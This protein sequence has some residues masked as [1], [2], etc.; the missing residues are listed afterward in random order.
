M[1]CKQIVGA[2]LLIVVTGM[3][4][5][6]TGTGGEGGTRTRPA[7]QL[8]P[9]PGDRTTN[10][11]PGLPASV[12][13]TEGVLQRV[14]LTSQDGK[15]VAGAFSPDRRS[16]RSTQPL[17]FGQTYTWSGTAAVGPDRRLLP[18]T[19]SFSTVAP[20]QE[21]EGT[22]NID[23]GAVVGVAAPIILQFDHEV[24]DK[25]AVERVLQ[26]QASVPT[27]GAWAWLPDNDDGSR[28]HYRPRNYWLP[29]TQVS[30][31]ARLYGLPYGEGSY[32]TQDLKAH[33]TVGR[34]QIVKADVESHRMIVV[35]DGREVMNFP[36]SYGLASDPVRNT[37]NGIHVVMSKAETVLM[38]N[39][40]YG[41]V[42]LPEHWAVRISNNGEFIHANPGT[43]G[44][45]GS[46]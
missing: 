34:S 8:S 13:V 3:L 12:K 25:A 20:E 38:S 41:Y 24:T 36:A 46:D 37:T 35:R 7:P 39:P 43:T 33:F 22:L 9:Q 14:I 6:C 29:G 31:L 21:V 23:D 1:R 26:V 18:V 2:L 19:G 4:T 40:A 45:Q 32:G 16:W 42:N 28:V 17:A 15:A 27:E 5:G 11:S 44:V 30:V 10:V